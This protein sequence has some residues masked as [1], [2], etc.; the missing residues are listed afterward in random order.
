MFIHSASRKSIRI[1]IGLALVAFLTPPLTSPAKA[2]RTI[3]CSKSGCSDW[4]RSSRRATHHDARQHRLRVARLRARVSRV[5]VSRARTVDANGNHIRRVIGYR[6]SG[7]P[8]AYCGCGLARYLGLHDKRLWKAWNWAR[9][10]PRTNAHAGA[11]AV[12]YHHVMLLERH[13][14]GNRWLVRSYNG[15]RHLSWLYV[16]DVRGYVFVNPHAAIRVASGK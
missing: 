16:R 3:S 15:G 12:R 10:F 9:L 2:H 14:K 4:H 8:H 11:A 13:I 7:C 1:G 6:P 5:R